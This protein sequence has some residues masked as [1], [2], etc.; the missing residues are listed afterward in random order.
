MLTGS[1]GLP[2]SRAGDDRLA[3][4]GNKKP[5]LRYPAREDATDILLVASYVGILNDIDE[6]VVKVRRHL[7]RSPQ[8][9]LNFVQGPLRYRCIAS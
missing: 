9:C 3:I 4:M 7:H 6:E 1:S 5:I 8:Q 2:D